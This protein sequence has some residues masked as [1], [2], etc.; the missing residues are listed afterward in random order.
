MWMC[1]A[2]WSWGGEMT[3]NDRGDG[4][5]VC[6]MI[7]GLGT[8]IIQMNIHEYSLSLCKAATCSLEY[9]ITQEFLSFFLVMV[10]CHSFAAWFTFPKRQEW[11]PKFRCRV[12]SVPTWVLKLDRKRWSKG[13]IQAD[14]IVMKET[15]VPWDYLLDKWQNMQTCLCEDSFKIWIIIH[16]F[17]SRL[18]KHDFELGVFAPAWCVTHT[19]LY[20]IFLRWFPFECHVFLKDFML[21]SRKLQ[22]STWIPRIQVIL[23]FV[24]CRVVASFVVE[25]EFVTLDSLL[26][27]LPLANS[28][29]HT[30]IHTIHTYMQLTC[31]YTTLQFLYRWWPENFHSH[32]TP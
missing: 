26:L 2:G 3:E 31:H 29:L 18:F 6:E 1:C 23:E 24:C 19:V 30:S 32:C 12:N 21:Q 14:G 16:I 8:W 28:D 25:N 17:Y 22:F 10:E 11:N 27:A 9:P 13:E 4:H 20:L 15:T 7:L 5:D